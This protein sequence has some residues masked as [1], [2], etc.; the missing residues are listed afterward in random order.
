MFTKPHPVASSHAFLQSS[1][2]YIFRENGHFLDILSIS[3]FF[4]SIRASFNSYQYQF[5]QPLN[6]VNSYQFQFL[7]VPIRSVF[8]PDNS[9]RQVVHTIRS[10]FLS[11]VLVVWPLFIYRHHHPLLS[12][13]ASLIRYLLIAVIII[14]S[15]L[16]RTNA[17]LSLGFEKLF[18]LRIL[19]RVQKHCKFYSS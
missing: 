5:V 16:I 14:I 9:S 15:Q 1:S 11:C 7:S 2:Q 10:C 6:Q 4:Q 19:Y 17:D 3:V 12:S 13:S 18:R 8:V